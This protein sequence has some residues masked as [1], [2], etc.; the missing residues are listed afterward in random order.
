[1]RLQPET[2]NLMNFAFSSSNKDQLRDLYNYLNQKVVT[3]IDTLD[4]SKLGVI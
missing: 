3:V 2:W 1:M 4:G